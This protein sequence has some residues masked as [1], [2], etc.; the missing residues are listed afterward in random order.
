MFC[1]KCNKPMKSNI[2]SADGNS[3][4]IV[5]TCAMC[6]ISVIFSYAGAPFYQAY[7][8]KGNKLDDGYGVSPYCSK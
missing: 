8:T 4:V 7:D 5:S 6:N 2:C 1:A 3:A